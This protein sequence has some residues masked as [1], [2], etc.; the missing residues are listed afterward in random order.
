MSAG[1]R[2][3]H[4]YLTE[5]L[6]DGEKDREILIRDRGRPVARIVSPASASAPPFP[7]LLAFRRDM[8][9]LR[10]AASASIISDRGDRFSRAAPRF[11][12]RCTSMRARR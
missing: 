3:V 1:V 2:K 9:R 12:G 8:P 5:L 7:N 6:A 4:Q 10:P 11:R